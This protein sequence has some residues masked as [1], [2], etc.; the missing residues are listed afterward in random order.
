MLYPM[1]F[2]A[3]MHTGKIIKSHTSAAALSVSTLKLKTS[4]TVLANL[5]SE[6]KQWLHTSQ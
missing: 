2:P 1:L 3:S 4:M 6:R 5:I